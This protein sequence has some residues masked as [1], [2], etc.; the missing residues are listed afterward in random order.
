MSLGTAYG[1]KHDYAG[2]PLLQSAHFYAQ[3]ALSLVAAAAALCWVAAYRLSSEK[4]RSSVTFA[5]WAL[6]LYGPALNVILLII[7]PTFIFR[8][9][10]VSPVLPALV[11]AT[12][13][14]VLIDGGFTWYLLRS[15]YVKEQYR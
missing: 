6:W 8:P 1:N 12:I 4:V 11:G 5:I 15:S 9:F 14:D 2:D 10:D 7:V 3:I 13:R